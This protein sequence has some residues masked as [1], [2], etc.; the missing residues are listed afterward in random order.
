MKN[1]LDTLPSSRPCVANSRCVAELHLA[2][3]RKRFGGGS[4]RMGWVAA[5]V[6]SAPT[7]VRGYRLNTTRDL[8]LL[9]AKKN[10][11]VASVGNGG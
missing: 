8:L 9:T 2:T 1:S 6:S 11:S 7:A 3:A 4:A 10:Q 5:W